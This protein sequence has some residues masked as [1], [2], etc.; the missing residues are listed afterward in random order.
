MA[1]PLLQLQ[2]VV[3]ALMWAGQAGAVDPH[4]VPGLDDRPVLF[5]EGARC[6]PETGCDR[7]G[8]TLTSP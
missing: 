4:H 7:F 8:L 5:V 6:N 3:L 1:A 2:L